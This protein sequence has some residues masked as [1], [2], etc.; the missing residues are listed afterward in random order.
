LAFENDCWEIHQIK[1]F[2]NQPVSFE[3]RNIADSICEGLNILNEGVD[4]R[5]KNLS[6]ADRIDAVDLNIQKEPL[7]FNETACVLEDGDS[8]ADGSHCPI[9]G[10]ENGSCSHLVACSD[11]FGGGI[12]GGVVDAN[13]DEMIDKVKSL[14]EYC[15]NQNIEDCGLG[16]AFNEILSKTKTR[17]A[18]GEMISDILWEYSQDIEYAICDLIA[19]YRDVFHTSWEF[20][21]M[22]G[23]STIYDNYWCE[24]P[25]NVIDDLSDMLDRRQIVK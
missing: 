21:G 8:Y 20:D 23:M 17:E 7:R 16:L 3:L 11:R 4:E 19:E 13:K 2:A 24:F 1:S 6:E 14:F 18:E 22:P 9:C 25:N 10:E 5:A 15:I 12:F